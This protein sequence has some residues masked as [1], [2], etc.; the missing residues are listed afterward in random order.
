MPDEKLREIA[1][2][3]DMIVRGYAFTKEGNLVRILNL[4]D[5]L[6]GM[7]IDL[8]GTMLETNMDEMEQALVKHIW[9]RDSKYMRS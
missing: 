6:S 7:L 3:A 9:L 8:D 5:G 4:N 2:G 1:D